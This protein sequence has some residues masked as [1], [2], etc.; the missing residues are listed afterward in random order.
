MEQLCSAVKELFPNKPYLFI[1]GVSRDKT[2]DPI[3]RPLIGSG[4]SIIATK[5][6]NSRALEPKVM[7]E[8]LNELGMKKPNSEIFVFVYKDL[9]LKPEECIFIDDTKSNI[10]AAKK[11]GFHTVL[12]TNLTKLVKDLKNHGVII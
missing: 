4:A 5:A 10:D 12:F 2:L 8:R 6:L 7:L 1:L 3:L 9:K 11:E